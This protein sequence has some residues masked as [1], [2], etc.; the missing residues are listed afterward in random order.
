M[1]TLLVMFILFSVSITMEL[2]EVDSDP[3]ASDDSDYDP[4]EDE[5]DSEDSDYG[6]TCDV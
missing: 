6:L 5:V 2:D 4:E 1:L 3:V